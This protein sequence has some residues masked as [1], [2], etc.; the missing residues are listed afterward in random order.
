MQQVAT[1]IETR[2]PKIETWP[3]K[4]SAPVKKAEP[5]PYFPSWEETYAIIDQR[6]GFW[7]GFRMLEDKCPLTN[8]LTVWGYKDPVVDRNLRLPG[9][10]VRPL[11]SWALLFVCLI[12]GGG[13]D[14][15]GR[16]SRPEALAAL[17][18]ARYDTRPL[19]VRQARTLSRPWCR[20]QWGRVYRKARDCA[21]CAAHFLGYYVQG[22]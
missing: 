16:V 5:Q 15:S 8:A 22:R 4:E 20:D 14:G 1:E 6:L 7:V 13:S 11:P 12:D 9:G 3:L 18:K 10:V 17:R 19:S 21:R 2:P